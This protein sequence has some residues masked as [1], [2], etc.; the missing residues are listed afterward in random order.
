MGASLI[1]TLNFHDSPHRQLTPALESYLSLILI[2]FTTWEHVNSAI[3][4]VFLA[5][6]IT[7]KVY[8]E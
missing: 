8:S 1:L 3:E 7:P 6:I 5:Y 4:N 2:S